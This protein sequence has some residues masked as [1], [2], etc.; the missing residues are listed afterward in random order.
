MGQ[1]SISSQSHF[2][3]INPQTH[4]AEV[5]KTLGPKGKESIPLFPWCVLLLLLV[6]VGPAPV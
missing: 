6:P 1:M 5:S 4:V 2:V 3:P